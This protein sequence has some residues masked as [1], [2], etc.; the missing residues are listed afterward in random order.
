MSLRFQ[1]RAAHA[2]RLAARPGFLDMKGKA[3]WDAWT[4][5]K[6]ACPGA[7]QRS[8]AIRTHV[9]LRLPRRVQLGGTRADARA[10][11]RKTAGM[12]KDAAMQKYIETVASLKA[13]Y[14]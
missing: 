12:A 2:R 4:A 3:K 13:K 6:G 7:P 14:A 9:L 1:A 5:N 11:S 10:A 8:P